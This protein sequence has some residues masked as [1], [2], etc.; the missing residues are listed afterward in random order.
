[1]SNKILVVILLLGCGAYAQAADNGGSNEEIVRHKLERALQAADIPKTAL[2]MY[3]M[4]MGAFMPG[5]PAIAQVGQGGFAS[6]APTANATAWYSL[7]FSVYPTLPPEVS[8]LALAPRTGELTLTLDHI[9]PGIDHTT[10]TMRPVI[11]H[12]ALAWRNTC[13]SKSPLV[14]EVFRC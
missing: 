4:E 8:S 2:A 13:S 6:G 5:G 14:K 10:V 9:Q 3:H 11:E 1:M 12:N 7:G